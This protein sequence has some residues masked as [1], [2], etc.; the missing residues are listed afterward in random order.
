MDLGNGGTMFCSESLKTE[1]DQVVGWTPRNGDTIKGEFSK[2]EKRV[3]A[4]VVDEGFQR[5]GGI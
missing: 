5:Q 1:V 4:K 2:L 3:L